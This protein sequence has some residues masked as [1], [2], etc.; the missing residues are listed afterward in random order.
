MAKRF[1]EPGAARAITVPIA[2]LPSL[3]CGPSSLDASVSGLTTGAMVDSSSTLPPLG[4]DG[5]GS[6]QGSSD[7]GS[8]PDRPLLCEP[9]C[10]I[11]L[12]VVWAHEG[13][14]GDPE[15]E[16]PDSHWVPV[17]VHAADGGLTVA[18]QRDSWVTLHRLDASGALRWNRPLPLPCDR[19]QLG[20]AVR[21]PSGDLLLG[22]V[23]TVIDG[24][25]AAISGRYD[26]NEDA[27]RWWSSHPVTQL[28]QAPAYSGEILAVG[29]T[30]TAQ[31]FFESFAELETPLGAIGVLVV[32][33][34][35]EVLERQQLDLQN[36]APGHRPLQ[37][38][39]SP[40]GEVVVSLPVGGVFSDPWTELGA[41]GDPLWIPTTMLSM[42]RIVDDL[43][44]DERG[45]TLSVSHT[46][47]GDR[48]H[49][50]LDD[51][52]GLEPEPRWVATLAVPSTTESR[53]DLAAGP[54][55][56]LYTAVRTT[57]AVGEPGD[58]EEQGDS[59]D[60][61][62]VE[63]LV[64][65]SLARWSSDGELRWSTSILMDIVE[66]PRP[67]LLEL[68]GDDLLLATVAGDRLRVER[69]EQRC[70]CE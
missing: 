1:L 41:M 23:G 2:L 17:V 5:G 29:E 22:A 12:P 43:I 16:P 30:I 42:P 50:L 38:R 53:I 64:G 66:A 40:S 18:E 70:V 27:L 54:D 55:G 57:Q 34:G 51:R 25:L 61:P 67:V 39:A 32:G 60:D 35:G 6:T 56:D 33:E 13:V 28:E 59:E 8:A 65:L 26:P 15:A 10:H 31:L 19:C 62:G 11:T 48:I 52:S 9:G 3:A 7:D 4:D 44:V 37:M 45:H 24:G 58:P 46:F 36:L 21:H 49:V 69:R 68:E 20:H 63:P 47:D 14:P